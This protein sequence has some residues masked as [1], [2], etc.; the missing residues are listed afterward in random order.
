TIEGFHDTIRKP[1]HG[2]LNLLTELPYDAKSLGQQIGYEDF[3]MSKE[4]YYENLMFKPT[5]NIN[6]FHSGHDGDETKTIIP[7]TA[8]LKMDMRLVVDQDPDDIFNKVVQHVASHAPD[9]EVTKGASMMPSRTP[10]HLDV[11][12]N[13]RQAVEDAFN[14][15]PILTPSMGGSLPDYVWTKILKV[16]SV[17]VP[18]ANF[19]EANHAPNENIGIKN[20]FN[21]I[22]CTCH[23]IHQLGHKNRAQNR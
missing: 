19:D 7:S 17:V 15:K 10:Y 2:E 18:Y 16:P 3:N 11:I 1:T 6:G 20:F 4:A 23:V 21:G 8:T 13:I 12:T 14:D 5:M 22:I 9:I